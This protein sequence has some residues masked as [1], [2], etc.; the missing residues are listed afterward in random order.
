[1]SEGHNQV[2]QVGHRLS[3]KTKMRI[4][5]GLWRKVEMYP[6]VFDILQEG[7]RVFLGFFPILRRLGPLF[8]RCEEV[9][10]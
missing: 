9:I 1:M 5:T 3:T 6:Y 8:C 2:P 10:G 7:K 4:T